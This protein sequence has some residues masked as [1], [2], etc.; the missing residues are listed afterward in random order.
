MDEEDGGW[1][2]VAEEDEEEQDAGADR[3]DEDGEGS[4][5]ES[6]SS[7]SEENE[8]DKDRRGKAGM[9]HTIEAGKGGSAPGCKKENQGKRTKQKTLSEKQEKQRKKKGRK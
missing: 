3:E 2:Q 5:D 1:N 9:Q 6:D 7:S 8:N 4:G